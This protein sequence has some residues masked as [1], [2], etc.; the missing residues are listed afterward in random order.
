MMDTN[1]N[2]AI[3]G[4][5]II[6][7]SADD[8]VFALDAVT[9]ELI[10]ETQILDYRLTPATQTSGP[11]IA[12]GKVI[13]GR[14]C[15]RRADRNP[16]SSRR[17]TP[18]RGEVWRRRLIPAPGGAWRR[19][20]GRRAVRRTPARRF[21]DGAQLRPRSES[22]LRRNFRHIASAE[23]HVGRPSSRRTS[24]TPRRWRSM[25]TRA[26]STGTTSISTT[27]GT[28]ITVRATT[29]RY[30]GGSGSSGP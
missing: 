4:N 8:Y 30:G 10:W 29:D 7:T 11:I 9:G 3:Y 28:W 27:T 5:L 2:V 1:R 17:T 23:V 12:D 6:D 21:L 22:R 13:S 24:I 16:A 25:P 18:Y 20:L 19:D 15:G 26:K 14:S